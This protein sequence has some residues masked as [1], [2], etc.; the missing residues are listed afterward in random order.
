MDQT[1][2]TT[3]EHDSRRAAFAAKHP[4]LQPEPKG[5]PRA[6]RGFQMTANNGRWLPYGS[7]KLQVIVQINNHILTP[8]NPKYAGGQWHVEGMLVSPLVLG[9]LHGIVIQTKKDGRDA[10]HLCPALGA[11]IGSF[12]RKRV[13][14]STAKS[15]QR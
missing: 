12:A 14:L 11:R 4:M 6:P 7:G 3:S 1:R 5:S 15:D 10:G 2:P 8:D 13:K 9:R